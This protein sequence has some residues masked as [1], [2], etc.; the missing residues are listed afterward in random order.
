MNSPSV[1]RL[2]ETEMARP[3]SS[4]MPVANRVEGA[5]EISPDRTVLRDFSAPRTL[6]VVPSRQTLYRRGQDAR[7]GPG[8]VRG[9]RNNN[10]R[11]EGSRDLHEG[12][13]RK[14]CRDHGWRHGHGPRTGA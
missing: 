12:F 11:K 3:N 5:T 10:N 13:C 1:P 9:S 7:L 4:T 2:G 14:D 6:P 8:P